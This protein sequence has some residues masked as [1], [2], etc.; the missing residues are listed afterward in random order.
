VRHEAEPVESPLTRNV[1]RPLE[2]LPVDLDRL[3]GLNLDDFRWLNLY[4]GF[5]LEA[6]FG[7]VEN[8]IAPRRC[9][10]ENACKFQLALCFLLARDMP[11]TLT[12]VVV[13]IG[14]HAASKLEARQVD[15]DRLVPA[16]DF[17]RPAV[18]GSHVESG[19]R[20]AFAFLRLDGDGKRERLNCFLLSSC[21]DVLALS[22]HVLLLLLVLG[23]AQAAG[24]LLQARKSVV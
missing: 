18:V 5:P 4:A 24:S 15:H 11:H 13:E 17:K 21:A 19:F 3:A 2:L 14:N 7:T 20:C 23:V 8:L 1:P 12:L 9:R 10:R 6:V 16:V 22:S